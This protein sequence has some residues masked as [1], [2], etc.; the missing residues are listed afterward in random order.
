MVE[1]HRC[2]KLKGRES[3]GFFVN[4]VKR[5]NAYMKSSQLNLQCF[6]DALLLVDPR[7]NH[8]GS[9][10]V[11]WKIYIFVDK[12]RQLKCIYVIL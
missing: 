2:P 9:R 4:G 1:R 5:I 11:M 7:F 3:W 8:L 10:F 6:L 12:L